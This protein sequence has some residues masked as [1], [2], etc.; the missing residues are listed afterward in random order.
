[1]SGIRQVLQIRREERRLK[2][3]CVELAEAVRSKKDEAEAAL[4]RRRK[5]RLEVEQLKAAVEASER[6]DTAKLDELHK[7]VRT[8]GCWGNGGLCRLIC[9]HAGLLCGVVMLPGH[10]TG[11]QCDEGTYSPIG[12]WVLHSAA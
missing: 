4:E 3:R 2:L 1:M 12:H 8:A 9:V 11:E 5:L 7:Q 10:G 6:A